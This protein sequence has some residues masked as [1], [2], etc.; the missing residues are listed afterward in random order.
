METFAA[1]RARAA[2]QKGGGEA[3]DALLASAIPKSPE[4]IAATPDD[5]MLAAFIRP[6]FNTGLSWKVIEAKW[7]GFEEAFHGFDAGWRP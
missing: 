3:L 7:P 4:K 1:I 5:R 2:E 6:I